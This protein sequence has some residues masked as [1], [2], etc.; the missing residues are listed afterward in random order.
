MV[1]ITKNFKHKKYDLYLRDKCIYS[2]SKYKICGI[3]EDIVLLN[4]YDNNYLKASD[5]DCKGYVLPK[6]VKKGY[7]KWVFIESI[8]IIQ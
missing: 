4:G 7:S 5:K 3:Y 8:Y 1:S 6:A 2:C